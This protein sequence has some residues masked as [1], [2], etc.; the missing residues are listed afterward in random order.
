MRTRTL[1]LLA[2]A[3]GI[4][5]LGA[6]AGLLFQLSTRKPIDAA[7]A[8]G[9]SVRVGD[10]AVTVVGSSED[11]GT[12]TAR[13]IIG[14]TV[15]A[16]PTAGFRLIASGRERPVSAS[17]CAPTGPTAENCSVSFDVGDADGVSR[18]LLYRRGEAQV[19]WV[20]AG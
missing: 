11:A 13:I 17:D 3:C 1:L 14:G 16:A 8:I 20:L 12:L 19:R 5:I 2:L 18:V 7:V 6:G 15:D 4:A 10:M 9:E